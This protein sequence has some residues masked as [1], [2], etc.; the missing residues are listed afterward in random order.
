MDKKYFQITIED[1]KGN[2]LPKIMEVLERWQ[3]GNTNLAIDVDILQKG[4]A[5]KVRF[6]TG[7]KKSFNI[8]IRKVKSSLQ[9]LVFHPSEC[10]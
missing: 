10:M 6:F 3:T 7:T 5:W 4:H 2:H 9:N 1:K 8:K